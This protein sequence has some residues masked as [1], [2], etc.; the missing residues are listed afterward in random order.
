MKDAIS[1]I[2]QKAKTAAHR[3]RCLCVLLI[4]K[5]N[6]RVRRYQNWQ[7]KPQHYAHAEYDEDVECKNCGRVYRG[8]YCPECG[9]AADTPRITFRSM[10]LR[11]LDVWG[12][13]NRSMPRTLVHLLLRPGYMITDY[14][15]GRRQPYFPPIKM[16]F[17]LGAVY[18]LLMAAINVGSKLMHSEKSVG[19][20]V[21]DYVGLTTAE[22]ATQNVVDTLQTAD[23]NVPVEVNEEGDTIVDLLGQ[24]LRDDTITST[25]DNTGKAKTVHIDQQS[26]V[27]KAI[28]GMGK[29]ELAAAFD[30]LMSKTLV[31][32]LF[33]LS[34][35]YAVMTK[36]FFR[37]SPRCQNY[38]FT[39]MFF[40]QIL[41]F[42]QVLLVAIILACFGVKGDLS[43]F[44]I[45]PWWLHVLLLTIVY[46]QM[47]GVSTRSSIIRTVALTIVVDL[48]IVLIL[49]S[50]IVLTVLSVIQVS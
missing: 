38:N 39:E 11:T 3:V 9:Q 6:K 50:V 15:E 47:F 49:I 21:L 23:A 42:N 19:D 34:L 10:I 48:V 43:S 36:A 17:V 12:F 32:R 45:I 4:K 18:L 41:I 1:G 16:L 31:M 13:G 33:V 26:G 24:I 25:D 20:L 44:T 2:L 7:Q 35:L 29:S 5:Y 27:V 30:S 46:K 28:R 22:E 40:A 37:R 8:A 14:I